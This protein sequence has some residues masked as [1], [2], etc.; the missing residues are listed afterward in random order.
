MQL[1]SERIYNHQQH[2][3]NKGGAK[4]TNTT[5]DI[6]MMPTKMLGGLLRQEIATNGYIL[7]RAIHEK[8]E[9]QKQIPG[10][11]PGH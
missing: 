1:T 3:A 11:I 4:P 8:C 9:K 7:T 10:P 5:Q 2:H 6:T